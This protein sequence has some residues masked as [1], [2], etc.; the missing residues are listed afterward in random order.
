MIVISLISHVL[1]LIIWVFTNLFRFLYEQR[2]VLSLYRNIHNS[3]RVNIPF[4][5]DIMIF[6]K[7]LNAFDAVGS[8]NVLGIRLHS[9]PLAVFQGIPRI[10]YF[11][12]KVIFRNLLP[13]QSI[14][15]VYSQT[16]IILAQ[17]FISIFQL[18]AL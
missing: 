11:M 13:I 18:L 6:L 2:L 14:L 15:I 10:S 4:S 8:I 9:I 12:I 7:I 17:T 1:I 5:F 16:F 3:I